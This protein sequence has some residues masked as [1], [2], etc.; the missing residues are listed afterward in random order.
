LKFL[1]DY[2]V[3][4]LLAEYYQI[5]LQL[6]LNQKMN[7]LHLLILRLYLLMKLVNKNLHLL[8]HHLL[9]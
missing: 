9:M 6:L 3:V 8:H 5:L 2:L 4:D 7:F 1:Q